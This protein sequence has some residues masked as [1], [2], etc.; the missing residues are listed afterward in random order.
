MFGGQRANRKKHAR[1]FSTAHGK[2]TMGVVL[3]AAALCAAV[4]VAQ[5]SLCWFE[6]GAPRLSDVYKRYDGKW[7]RTAVPFTF[8]AT[9][10]WCHKGDFIGSYMRKASRVQDVDAL[11][12]AASESCGAGQRTGT[13]IHLRLG[14]A[15][16]GQCHRQC[17]KEAPGWLLNQMIHF[18]K[19]EAPPVDY[20]IKY[21]NARY[22]GGLGA[23]VITGN[24]RGVCKQTMAQYVQRLREGLPDLT[25]YD[26]RS[27]ASDICE[28]TR[29][30]TFVQGLGGFSKLLASVAEGMVVRPE[31]TG[32]YAYTNGCKLGS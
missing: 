5:A 10:F 30:H 3:S 4:A 18:T 25:V 29:S 2:P 21:I 12:A 20:V 11:R 1:T 23:T 13:V 28:V 16:V 22:P 15:L 9:Q 14:D 6:V 17:N 26:D 7:W 27:M 32:M 31:G 19:Y 8:I 24:H